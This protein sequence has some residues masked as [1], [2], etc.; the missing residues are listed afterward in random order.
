VRVFDRVSALSAEEQRITARAVVALANAIV[1][2]QIAGVRRALTWAQ[3]E[4]DSR[5]TPARDAVFVRAVDRAGRYLPGATCLAKSLALVRMLREEGRVATVRFGTVR[6]DRFAA[7]A[8]VECDGVALTD[9]LASIPLP[10]AGHATGDQ[11]F[12]R[13]GGI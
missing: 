4:R 2:L 9:T 10:A 13:P 3:W 8:W 5:M 7:H 1:I 11:E 12:R 6:A